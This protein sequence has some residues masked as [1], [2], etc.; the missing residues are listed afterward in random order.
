MTAL[1]SK[2]SKVSKGRSKARRRWGA[3][4][5]PHVAQKQR[6]RAD[7]LQL[8]DCP[9]AR[10]H[11]LLIVVGRSSRTV[12]RVARRRRTRREQLVFD[13]GPLVPGGVGRVAGEEPGATAAF[14]DLVAVDVLAGQQRLGGRTTHDER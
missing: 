14:R 10:V 3:Q 12:A 13:P 5:Q 1:G 2:V 9:V 4:E 6:E 7:I 11:A 8:S